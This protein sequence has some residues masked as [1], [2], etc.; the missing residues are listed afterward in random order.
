MFTLFVI[1]TDQYTV[2]R[3][4]GEGNWGVVNL[5]LVTSSKSLIA[6]K[7]VRKDRKLSQALGS[8]QNE[9]EVLKDLSHD[10]VV[11]FLGLSL[12]SFTSF[13]SKLL[14]GTSG[15]NGNL[16]CFMEYVSGG[17]ME[18]MIEALGVIP[19]D[20]IRVFAYQVA[21]GLNYLHEKNIIHR[22][23]Q[24]ANILLTD[25]GQ[26][27]IAD[28]GL[29]KYLTTDGTPTPIS[30]SPIELAVLLFQGYHLVHES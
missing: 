22:D 10:H 8:L 17:T 1:D 4:L 12:R 11:K 9:M 27:I 13:I 20:D 30:F 29:A 15:G 24:P 19:E 3:S 28:F 2:E 18:D 25:D 5:V 21:S 16:R 7:E 23:I 26:A 6:V 14:I